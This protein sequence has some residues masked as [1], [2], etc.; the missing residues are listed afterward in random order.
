M[1][2]WQRGKDYEN[3][4]VRFKRR[5]W[6]RKRRLPVTITRM[7][8]EDGSLMLEITAVFSGRIG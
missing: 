1:E 6:Q 5:W 2:Q 8:V 3:I 7:Y 4:E